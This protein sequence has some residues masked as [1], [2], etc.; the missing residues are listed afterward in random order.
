MPDRDSDAVPDGGVRGAA[1]ARD[2]RSNYQYVSE[3]VERPNL[4]DALD[5]RVDGEVRFDTYTRQMY[6]TD[7]SAYE[8]TPIGVVFPRNTAAR[9]GASSRRRGRASVSP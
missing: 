1:P 9:R 5:A 2:A 3:T 4:V 6:A 7:S 8:V